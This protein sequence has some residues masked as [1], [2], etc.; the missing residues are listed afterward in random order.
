MTR[1]TTP[2]PRNGVDTPTL[3]ATLDAV[4]AKRELARF[5]FRAN[6]RWVA[7]THSQSTIG[8]FYGAGGEQQRERAFRLD[9]DHPQVLVGGDNGP[10]PVE[11]VLH[12]LATCL[13]AGLVNIAAAR[14]IELEEVESTVE[15]DIDLQGIF[16]MD[17]SVRNGYQGIKA[18]FRIRGNASEDD[19]AGLLAQSKAR[20][21]VFDIVTNSVP[22]EI[23]VEAR[24]A[25]A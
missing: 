14:G 10:T 12:A 15:G 11:Y 18:S 20:S 9:G 19:L 13:T 1:R 24:A 25:A 5:Q 21:A 4:N 17:D 23:D 22:V 3:F 2:T 7:G 8:G 16:G 6:N